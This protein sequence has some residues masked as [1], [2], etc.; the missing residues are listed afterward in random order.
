MKIGIDARFFGSQGKGLGRYTQK[1]IEELEKVDIHNQ[2][3]IFLNKHNINEYNPTNPNFHKVLANIPWYSWQEQ[4]LLPRL[5]QKYHLDL[6]HF[7][8]FN[9]PLLYRKPYVVTIHDLIL[10]EY[11]TRKASRLNALMYMVKN[12]AYRLVIL[13]A[14]YTAKKIITISEYTRQSLVKH[15]RI[16]AQS[17]EMI[18]EGIDLEKF[19]PLNAQSFDF[20]SFHLVPENYLLYVGNVYPHKNI[21]V[22][23]KVFASLKKRPTINSNLKLVLVGKKDHFLEGIIQQ[24]KDLGLEDSVVFP[25][26][27]PDEQLISLYESCLCYVFP[28]LYEGFGLPPLEAIALGAPVVVSNTTCLPE[29]FGEHI[30]YFNPKSSQDMEAVLYEFI[31]NPDNRYQQK[32]FH[33]EIL[34]KYSWVDMA[35]STKNVYNRIRK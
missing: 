20:S 18:Y 28:S 19:N 7:P 5:L 35:E 3:Y 26:Y 6:V 17:M 10:L 2:Y 13:N 31:M 32:T 8:H 11:P 4:I 15:F 22:L 21:D 16:P 25:G 1:L 29:I 33:P 24:V 27:V 14:V 23:V 34:S 9:I 30:E 12:I